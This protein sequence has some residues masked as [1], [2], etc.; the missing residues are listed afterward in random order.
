MFISERTGFTAEFKIEAGKPVIERGHGV[1][2]V[3]ARF[4]VRQHSLYA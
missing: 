3:A 4:D 2:E 1:T